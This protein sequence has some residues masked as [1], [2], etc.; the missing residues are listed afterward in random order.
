VTDHR[1]DPS[2]DP[3]YLRAR[4]SLFSARKIALMASVVAGL[5]VAAFGFQSLP[6]G[7]SIVSSP[8]HAQVNN[9]VSKVAQPVGFADIVQ[10]VK[11]SV[12][13][14][15][16]TMKDKAA[17]ASDRSDDGS[18]QSGPPMERFFRQ[19]G[20]PQGTPPGTRNHHGGHG[21]MMG[22]GSGFFISWALSSATSAV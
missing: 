13:S 6:G 19:F 7:F 1:S 15:K 8:A 3:F 9:D 10:R 11:P 14:V 17:D 16:V 2:S 4:R 22:Q 12:I 21:V 20:G 18:D 5:G